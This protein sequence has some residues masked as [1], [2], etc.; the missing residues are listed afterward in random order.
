MENERLDSIV[1]A[2]YNITRSKAQKLIEKENIKVNGLS[3]KPSYKLKAKDVIQY[4]EEES[5][6]SA[7][8][9]PLDIIYEDDYLIVLNKQKGLLCH[10]TAHE[11]KTLVNALLYHTEKLSNIEGIERQ[12]IV[13]RLDKDTSGLMLIAKTNEA[14]T[15][16][17]KDIQTKKTIR[18]YLAVCHG[19]IEDDFG[20]INKP[21]AH[22]LGKTVKMYT[23]DNGLEA[24][25]HFKVIERF[26][27]GTFLSI[28]L[29]TGRT[30]QIRCHFA[31]INHPLVG[32][33]L[34]GAKS[35]QNGI[36]KGFK[37][38]GQVLMSYY[39]L[40]THPVTNEIMEFEIKKDNYHP[41]LLRTLNFL[42]SKN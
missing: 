39:L 7:E 12:G 17:K 34:Y 41:D 36:F 35:F 6:I 40:F 32:D 1:A 8:N 28:Q 22:S 30:H 21:L 23:N 14:H 18:K 4:K 2:K 25:T 38:D 37:T 9:I 24:I 16:L 29:E 26:N 10:R 11:T 33:N 15:V 5:V 27:S 13:H 31:S 19:I 3:V 42:R 20:T